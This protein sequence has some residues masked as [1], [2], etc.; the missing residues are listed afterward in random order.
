[1]LE[2]WPSTGRSSYLGSSIPRDELEPALLMLALPHHV[3]ALVAD[4]SIGFLDILRYRGGLK[5][6]CRAVLGSSW[7][8]AEPFT[9]IGF[10][11]PRSSKNKNMSMP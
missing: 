5:G 10:T 4:S 6:I 2:L 9:K 11:A 8:L 7:R 3:D 1:M